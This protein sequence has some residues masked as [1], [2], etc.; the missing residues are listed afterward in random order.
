MMKL[1]DS[2]KILLIDNDKMMGIFFRDTF[3]IHDN[4]KIYDVKTVLTYEEA[5]KRIFDKETQPNIIFLDV[6]TLI[7]KK[8]EIS[9]V[10]EEKCLNFLKGIK[11]NKDFSNIKIVVYSANKNKSLKNEILKLGIDGYLIKGE[12]TPKE[13]INYTNKLYGY[14]N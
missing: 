2:V 4:N 14:D 3:W 11:E 9:I 5:E 12:Y 8:E 7:N 6:D 13:L 10:K 1:K